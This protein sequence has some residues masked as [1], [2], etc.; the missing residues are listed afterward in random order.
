MAD[1]DNS[2]EQ[3]VESQEVQSGEQENVVDSQESYNSVRDDFR[4]VNTDDNQAGVVDQ[5]SGSEEEDG[6]TGEGAA[7]AESD[8]ADRNEH[9][10]T[11]EDNAAA[12]AARLRAT[13]EAEAKAAK[14][15]AEAKAEADRRIQAAGVINPYTGKPFSSIEEFE[16]YSKKVKDAEIAKKARETGKSVSQLTEEE[17]AAEYIRRKR[18]EESEAESKRREEDKQKEFFKNDL[19]DF[20]DRYPAVDVQKLDNNQAFRKFCGSRYGKEPLADLYESYV[21]LVGD[22]SKAATIKAEAKSARST[23]TG[24]KGGEVLSPA[25]K[26]ALDEWNK[27]NPEMAMTPKE[28][29]SR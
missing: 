18:Q 20:M 8:G 17:E 2:T 27:M 19:L 13:R 23:G 15:Q 4:M 12:K 26:K 5:Q 28:F 9:H 11:R 24:E 1:F 22:A 29:L 21:E 25:Q 10:Q 7:E 3:I 16:D 6:N 14:M